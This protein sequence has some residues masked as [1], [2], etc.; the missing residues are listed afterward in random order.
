MIE[1]RKPACA[2]FLRY[3]PMKYD[4]VIFDL[5]GTLWDSRESIAQSWSATLRAHVGSAAGVSLDDVTSIMGLTQGAIADKLFSQYGEKRHELCR[6]CMDG[7]IDYIK[8]HGALVY[9]GAEDMLRALSAHIKLFAVSNCQREYIDAFFV[10]TGFEKYFADYL[11]EGHTHLKKAENI[12]L[13]AARHGLKRPVYVG[14]TALD[15]Q[16]ARQ[17]GAAFIHAAYGFG[18]ADS[19]DGRIAAPR[20]LIGL[21]CEQG[22]NI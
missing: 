16:S 3:K 12:A 8:R 2:G 1:I 9:D 4:S 19:P 7:E 11:T 5:D 14:D 15:E 21:L 18:T 10:L 20:E 22:E 17:A 13:I 6:L